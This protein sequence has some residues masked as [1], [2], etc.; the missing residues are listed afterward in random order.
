MGRRKG[1]AERF[2][3]LAALVGALSAVACGASPERGSEGD[4]DPTV[5]TSE[6][7]TTKTKPAKHPIVLA[8]GFNASP[9]NEWGFH[10]TAA[11]LRSD[12]NT[13]VEAS[14]EPF[15]SVRVRAKSLAA[16]VDR[17]LAASGAAKVNILAHS[18]G[19]LDAR[20]LV[21]DLGYADRVASITTISTPHRGSAVADA[22]LSVVPSSAAVDALATCWAGTFTRESLAEGSDV[23]AA[24][25]DLAEANA[26]TFEAEHPIPEGVYAQSWAGVSAAFG[27]SLN[28]RREREVCEDR[29]WRGITKHD[30]MA[31]SLLPNA[32]FVAGHPGMDPND[33]MATV[34][35]AKWGNFRGCIPADH[36]DEV[37]SSTGV[38]A[39]GVDYVA[40]YR[41]VV[42]DLAGRGY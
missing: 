6:G 41:D 15:A 4:S 38:S 17:V 29:F 5:A 20:V 13:V 27:S 30:A 7:A 24:L 36:L 8:H 10:R 11:A 25:A 39:T 28:A 9:S 32:L 31:T 33:G 18:M 21:G 40:F 23:R 22:A 14:V 34:T 16:E 35:S 1:F 42:T 37:G 12:G 26:A 3:T 2:G 19:G